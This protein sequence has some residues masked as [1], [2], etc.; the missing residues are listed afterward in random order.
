MAS[1][2]T[3][4]IVLYK[5]SHFLPLQFYRRK[6]IWLNRSSFNSCCFFTVAMLWTCKY[7][8]FP[9][10]KF[11]PEINQRLP[12]V[13]SLSEILK[14]FVFKHAVWFSSINKHGHINIAI[15]C[16]NLRKSRTNIDLFQWWFFRRISILQCVL[17]PL[18]WLKF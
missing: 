12:L 4:A 2:P 5:I 18:K 6:V 10:T 14:L 13:P 3:V 15:E 8:C 16:V 7:K 11:R 17:F 9:K 1:L